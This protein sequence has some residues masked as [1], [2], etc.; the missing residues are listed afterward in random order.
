MSMCSYRK[1]PHTLC[2]CTIL[3]Y[4]DADNESCKRNNL[5]GTSSS[6]CML[7]LNVEWLSFLLSIHAV[8]TLCWVHAWR[9]SSAAT[10]R[11]R[12]GQMDLKHLHSSENLVEMG[13]KLEDYYPSGEWDILDV[14]AE[15]HARV[16]ECCPDEFYAGNYIASQHVSV[17]EKTE[18]SN[19]NRPRVYMS[20]TILLENKHIST[21]RVIDLCIV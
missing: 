16:Y 2:C 21:T 17:L 10:E 13:M 12:R 4:S 19:L 1:N 8:M 3:L 5:F 15:R 18:Y 14:P 20:Q 9:S 6:C 11:R 7:S